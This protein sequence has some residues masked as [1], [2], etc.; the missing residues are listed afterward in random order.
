[1]KTL[2]EIIARLAEIDVE[3][4][5]ATEAAQ[6]DALATEKG[7]LLARKAELEDLETR[8][9]GALDIKQGAGRV[10][11]T[12]GAVDPDDLRD[13][14]EYRKAFMRHVV[15]GAPLPAEFRDLTK[16]T[17]YTTD[18]PAVI[19]TVLVNR[20]VEKMETLG[21]ILPLVTRTSYKAGIAIPTSAVK[22]VATWV[23]EG[24][25]SDRQKKA[26][27]TSIMFGNFKLRCEVAWS[28]EMDAMALSAFEAAFVRQVSEAM[29][30]AIES[31]I[32]STDV[33]ATNP[34]GILAETPAD[35]QALTV[36]T[37]GYDTLIDAE[38][39][40]P[41]AYEGNAVWCMTKKTFMAFV[42]M[43]DAEGQPIARTNYGIGGKP[44]RTLLGR[45]VVLCGDYMDSFAAN[46][47]AGKIFAFLFDFREYA[48]NTIYD[49]G[50][51]RRQDWDTED[52]QVKAVMSCDG[53]VIDKNSLVTLAKK[54]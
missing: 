28:M 45:N 29:V 20:I 43:T 25:S 10:V 50:I 17:T 23:G 32:V 42:G 35:G 11:E 48:L 40:L 6:V 14:M 52:M 39:A 5:N 3:V 26:T 2:Q 24:G 22:P 51:Q 12:R 31:K 33:G 53:K 27:G 49:L 16:E 15:K 1:M 37:I 13:S 41:Q 44:E 9:Q 54:A 21:M 36:K 34:R 19:P 7:E 47:T 46:L 8:K 38:A 18:A 4:R 30:K